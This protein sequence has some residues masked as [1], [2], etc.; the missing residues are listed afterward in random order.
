MK[1]L[2]EI[3]LKGGGSWWIHGLQK[4]T[5]L[6][7]EL[8]HLVGHTLVGGTT[9]VGKSRL[10]ELLI[11]QGIV[12][13]EC[14]ILED[15]KNEGMAGLAGNMKRVCDAIKRLSDSRTSIWRFR[16]RVFGWT[17]CATMRRLPS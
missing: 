13:G 16:N 14:V 9:R 15:P 5:E 17:C 6:L 2:G 10:A 8:E 1:V 7:S 4:E 3:A 11:G 12:R